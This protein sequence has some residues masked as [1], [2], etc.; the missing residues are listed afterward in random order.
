MTGRRS[1]FVRLVGRALA[2]ALSSLIFIF[3]WMTG[4]RSFFVSFLFAGAVAPAYES[5]QIFMSFHQ[6]QSEARHK[7]GFAH[8]ASH[9]NHIPPAI[10]AHLQRVHSKYT[11]MM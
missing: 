11:M 4:R 2:P 8:Q 3:F 10:I 5:Y 7:A 9:P 1:F 6:T